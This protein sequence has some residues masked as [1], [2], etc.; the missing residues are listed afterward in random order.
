MI[1]DFIYISIFIILLANYIT[2]LKNLISERKYFINTLSHDF[3]VAILAQI[4]A[5][6]ILQTKSNFRNTEAELI[7]DLN[8]SSKLSLELINTLINTYKY[9]NNIQTLNYEE[10]YLSEIIN[11]IYNNF[12]LQIK[13]KDIRFK[14]DYKNKISIN[15]DKKELSKAIEILFLT[16]LYNANKNS[17]IIV[18]IKNIDRFIKLSISSRERG[19][20][21]PSFKTLA[22][23][24]TSF[25]Y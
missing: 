14:H 17:T 11:N 24:Q 13:T 16:A 18:E 20:T 10:F 19:L 4:R 15:A 8:E 1:K 2:L 22:S 12:L 9:K 23:G 25:T 3:R 7:N 5:L 6:N 21:R